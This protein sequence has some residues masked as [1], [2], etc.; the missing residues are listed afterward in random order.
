MVVFFVTQENMGKQ[1]K[2]FPR[3]P[4]NGT[5]MEG[6]AARICVSPSILGCLS[7]IGGQV[8][9]QKKTYVYCTEVSNH[10]LIQPATVYD[11]DFTGELWLI[12]P[13]DFF[14]YKILNLNSKAYFVPDAENGRYIYTFVSF[15]TLESYK[16]E[17]NK[18]DIYVP[19]MEME[20]LKSRYK[21]HWVTPTDSD[22]YEDNEI[23]SGYVIINNKIIWIDTN[24][25]NRGTLFTTPLNMPKKEY[26]EK[27]YC[28]YQDSCDGNGEIYCD[29]ENE[30]IEAIESLSKL[31][32]YN[33]KDK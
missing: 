21:M 26:R 12:E 20:R 25:D 1:V 11:A 28:V 23:Y 33:T 18:K 30:I 15:E 32:I 19:I 9:L 2:L 13:T 24:N 29:T 6:G 14:L 5:S 22:D 31:S 4:E 10:D 8:Y 17:I 7:A 3:L 27:L 16:R